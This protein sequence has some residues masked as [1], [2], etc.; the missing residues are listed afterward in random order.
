MQPED[1]MADDRE[2]EVEEEETSTE[3][4]TETE[5]EETEETET[6]TE[7]EGEETEAEEEVATEGEEKSLETDAETKDGQTLKK[8]SRGAAL[9]KRAQ[10]AEA[11]AARLREENAR[12]TGRIEGGAQRQPQGPT[13]DELAAERAREELMSP[14]ELVEHKVSK[15]TNQLRAEMQHTQFRMW[16]Q[17][18][19]AA[20]D[21]KVA[22]DPL[23]AKYAARVE[24]GIQEQRK[25]GLNVARERMFRFLVGDDVLNK[26]GPA[27]ARARSRTEQVRER[28]TVKK[29]AGGRSDTA[30]ERAGQRGRVSGKAR[31]EKDGVTF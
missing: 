10:T 17:S 14:A 28:E 1:R 30:T 25:N 15:A 23:Y 21:A 31:L 26:R 24:A 12:L 3:T 27:A 7:A 2:L 19:K 5:V 9:R 4:E 6:E 18:D 16:D 20:F 8:P 13:A 11:E 22:S 29:P